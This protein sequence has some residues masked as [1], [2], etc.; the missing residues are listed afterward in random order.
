MWKPLNETYFVLP[1][2][3]KVS[4]FILERFKDEH[5]PELRYG[6]VVAVGTGTLTSGGTR[7]P[8]QAKPGERIVFGAKVGH[9][10]EVDGQKLLLIAEQNVLAVQRDTSGEEL[11]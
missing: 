1:E 11:I 8:C 6:T 7:V 5:L 4:P 2:E 3:V 9:T 10:I